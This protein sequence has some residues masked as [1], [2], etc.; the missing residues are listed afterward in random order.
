MRNVL[1]IL[2]SVLVALGL[3]LAYLPAGIV[4]AGLLLGALVLLTD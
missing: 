3:G 1:L 4:A 2:A